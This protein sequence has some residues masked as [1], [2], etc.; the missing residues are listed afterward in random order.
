MGERKWR[1]VNDHWTWLLAGNFCSGNN[2]KEEF[3]GIRRGR[4]CQW[5]SF[6]GRRLHIVNGVCVLDGP[7]RFSSVRITSTVGTD[8]AHFLYNMELFVIQ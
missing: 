2:K 1:G 3:G 8:Q 7:N 6:S 5:F 4:L